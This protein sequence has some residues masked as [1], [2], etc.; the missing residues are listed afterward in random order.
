MSYPPQ[1]Q[2][3]Y[4]PPPPQPQKGGG[5]K[6]IIIVLAIVGVLCLG[7]A[8]VGLY[9]FLWAKDTTEEFVNNLPTDFPTDFPSIPAGWF[10]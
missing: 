1:P 2:P 6:I 5:G 7:C 9:F 3:G 4:G 8:G 10:F